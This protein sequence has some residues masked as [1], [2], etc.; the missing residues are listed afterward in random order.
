MRSGESLVP[1]SEDQ[2]RTIF[3]EGQPDWLENRAK[4]D[5]TGQGVVELLDTQTF[6]ELLN[7]PY[8]TNQQG[9]LSRLQDERLIEKKGNKFSILNIGALLLAKNLKEFPSLSRKAPRVIVYS[10]ESKLET[11]SDITGEK[12]YAVG[13]SGLVNYVNGKLPQN[14]EIEGAIRK[15][16]KLLP[17]IIHSL[18]NRS[19]NLYPFTNNR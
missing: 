10:G 19:L 9:V 13:F 8:P 17:E 16:V 5:L 18:L 15:E 12:G 11:L 7:L 14:E 3:A 2:L 6:F 4:T 1:M